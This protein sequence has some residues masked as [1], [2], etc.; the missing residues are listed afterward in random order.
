MA[1]YSAYLPDTVTPF[2]KERILVLRAVG[3]EASSAEIF[4][5]H[6]GL[7]RGAWIESNG[8]PLRDRAGVVRGGVIALRDITQRKT[9]EMEIR[10]LNEDLEEE[11]R[12]AP[13]NWRPPTRSWSLFRTPFPIIC[14]PLFAT[15]VVSRRILV[16]DFGSELMPEARAHLQRIEDATIR[17]GLLV[18]GLLGYARLGRQSLRLRPYGHERAGRTDDSVGS[19]RNTKDARWNGG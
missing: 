1:H 19:S 10:G 5:R 9:D 15:S 8:A 7:D 12:N 14:A 17:M 18:D 6:P 3:G 16:K 13:R 11:S 2:P 4:V